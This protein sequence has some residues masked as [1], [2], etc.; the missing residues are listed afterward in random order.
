DT[1]VRNLLN[2]SGS[3]TTVSIRD[4]PEILFLVMKI[5]DSPMQFDTGSSENELVISSYEE[6]YNFITKTQPKKEKNL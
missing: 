4:L 6:E 2:I 1:E 3:S 5:P